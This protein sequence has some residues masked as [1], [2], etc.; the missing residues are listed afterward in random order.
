MAWLSHFI[1]AMMYEWAC[2]IYKWHTPSTYMVVP[3]VQK[4][5]PMCWPMALY[6]G[7]SCLPCSYRSLPIT[8]HTKIP[9]WKSPFGWTNNT[10]L[11]AFA[12]IQG[13]LLCFICFV[14]AMPHL[15]QH[16]LPFFT[17]WFFLCMCFTVDWLW[18]NAAIKFPLS[19]HLY[20]STTSPGG[21]YSLFLPLPGHECINA[22]LKS[23][24]LFS[25]PVFIVYWCFPIQSQD[26][27]YSLPLWF[28]W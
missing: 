19:F 5:W 18:C 22:T 15:W 2:E 16:E 8:V 17:D 25:N 11:F 9:S 23:F 20:F 21:D 3:V 14:L 12:S 4:S 26:D 24:W 10:T 6:H 28:L 1:A 7:H 27:C 13:W